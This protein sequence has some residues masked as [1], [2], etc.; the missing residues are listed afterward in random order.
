MVSAPQL[1]KCKQNHQG[2]EICCI[3]PGNKVNNMKENR[4]A[5]V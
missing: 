5:E 3:L 4:G 1:Q 2:K